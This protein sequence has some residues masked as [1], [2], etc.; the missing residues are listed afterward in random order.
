MKITVSGSLYFAE[1]MKK[2]QMNLEKLGHEVLVPDHLELCLNRKNDV[3]S[4]NEWSEKEFVEGTKSHFDKILSSDAV[5]VF[6]L[7]KKGIEGYVGVST[8]G[9]ALM[10]VYKDKK[11]FFY[12]ELPD[13]SYIKSDLE[14]MGGIVINQD[15]S[16]IV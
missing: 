15:L 14:C 16:K 5:L 9:E 4:C 12:N 2:L 10:A 1:E 11:I 8:F 3:N 13:M 6:N 7:D